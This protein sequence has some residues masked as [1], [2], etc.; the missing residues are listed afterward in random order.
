MRLRSGKIINPLIVPAS[1][2]TKSFSCP[3]CSLQFPDRKTALKHRW[4]EH[5]KC[6]Q[7]KER[8]LGLAELQSHRQITEHC[9]CRECDIYFPN[10]GEHLTH[11]RTT[12]HT[13]PHHCCDC[14]REYTNQETLSYHCCDCDESLRNQKLFRRHFSGKKHI[15]KVGLPTSSSSRN[16]LYKCNKC[17]EAF[18]H[19]KQLKGHKPSHE[20][21]RCIPCPAGEECHKKFAMPSALLNHLESGCCSSGMTRAKMHQ[22]VFAHDRNRYI[23]SVEAVESIHSFEH[24]SANHTSHLSYV[25]ESS[26]GNPPEDHSTPLPPIPDDDDD[27]IS[28][29]SA[30]GGGPLTPTTSHSDWSIIGGAVLTPT[31][32]DNVSEWS[33][34]SEDLV[35]VSP[36]TLSFDTDLN[37]V[38]RRDFRSPKLHCQLCGPS[39][40]PFRTMRAYQAHVNSAAHAPKI[41]HCPLSLISEAKPL[42]LSKARHFS[43][44]GGL[45]QH[46]E[47]GKCEGGPDLYSKAIAFVE[48]QLKALGFSGLMLLS[49]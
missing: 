22:L 10:L 4:D 30:D 20:P 35:H 5:P 46:L 27:N 42:D 11:A 37:A 3:T 36:N 39:R 21:P 24:T 6:K 48:E 44:L 32:S 8:F 28:E 38:S 2:T 25:V 31:Y 26:S 40:K 9:Y 17:H 41:F 7:C 1:A 43:T 29:W 49:N 13:T 45:T 16:L 23:T 14:D 47:S 34:V 18:N 12:T 33:F 19:K 15:R